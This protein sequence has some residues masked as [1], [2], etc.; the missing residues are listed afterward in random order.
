MTEYMDIERAKEQVEELQKAYVQQYGWTTTSSTPGSFWLWQRNFA[1]VDKER[2][3]WWIKH[4]TPTQ[5]EAQETRTR[6]PAAGWG[7][8]KPEPYGLVGVPLDIA[9]SMTFR[10]LDLTRFGDP[11]DD[12]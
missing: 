2:L 10:T 12:D 8:S 6:M 11:I 3:D 9:V 1:D 4:T 7:P 5:R